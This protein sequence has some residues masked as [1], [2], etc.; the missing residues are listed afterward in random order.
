[1]LFKVVVFV[2][3]S[4]VC[5]TICL[6]LGRHDMCWFKQGVAL[7]V[8]NSNSNSNRNS[9]SN[10]NNNNS[11]PSPSP[12]L[13]PSPRICVCIFGWGTRPPSQ[14]WLLVQYA[15]EPPPSRA[16]AASLLLK[17][18]FSNLDS[19]TLYRNVR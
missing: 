14:L 19:G 16:V 6:N 13:P 4:K 17:L 7:A 15:Y 8:G 3:L 11:P 9:N 1:M 5:I 2:C 12:P 10:S 18:H